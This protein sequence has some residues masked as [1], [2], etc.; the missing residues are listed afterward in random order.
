[1]STEIQDTLNQ[2]YR[3]WCGQDAQQII[4]IS[5]DGSERRYFRIL[6]SSSPTIGAFNPDSKENE[7]FLSFSEHF[8]SHDLPVPEVFLSNRKRNIYL[9]Q[10][11]GNETL[12]SL[13]SKLRQGE[14]SSNQLV[15]LYQQVL[16]MLPRFQILAGKTLDYSI[17]YPRSDFDKQSIYWDL[18]YFKYHFLK[19]SEV[20]FDEQGLENDFKLLVA[21]L[22]EADCRYFLYR[23]FQSRNIMWFKK[24]LFFIDYQGGRRGALQYDVASL[25]MDAKADLSWEIRHEL[26]EYYLK[27]VADLIPL[28]HKSFLKYYLPYALVR[29]L[30]AFGA[31]GYRGLYQGKTH[32]LQS[33]PYALHTLKGLLAQGN[34]PISLPSLTNTLERMTDSESLFQRPGDVNPGLTVHIQSFSYKN[35]IPRDRSI[36]GGGFV[37][38]CR[39]LPNPGR[40]PQYSH[41]TGRDTDVIQFL[42]KKLE[43][44]QFISNT[45]KVVDQ[46]LKHHQSRNFTDLTVFY[47][48]TGGQHRSVYCAEKLATLLKNRNNLKINLSHRE[49]KQKI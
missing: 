35:G 2:L 12:F 8:K 13:C 48:C 44:T 39:I 7:A 20:P 43:V 49:L 3:T 19:L 11:L 9:L 22:M 28:D 17:C 4:P 31:Y 37:F 47:G 10:D 26:L 25:L 36:H 33:I 41:L 30:Q 38:D 21:F 23:D 6:G 15:K 24:R 1:M 29:I 16:E 40:F 42:K 46:A 34:I 45:N 14:K 5:A 27:V 32:F 18:N